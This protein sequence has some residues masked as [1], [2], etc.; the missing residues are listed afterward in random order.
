[1]LPPE[2]QGLDRDKMLKAFYKDMFVITADGKVISGRII[3]QEMKPRVYRASLYTGVVDTSS[4]ISPYVLF[5]EI[6]YPIN[7]RPKTITITPPIEEGYQSTLA[8]I[9]FIAYHKN[10]PVNDLRYLGSTEMLRL[11]W[12]DPWYSKFDNRNL[13]RHHSSSLL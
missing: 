10:I 5:T 6:E 13:K 2:L 4:T 11:D 3:N 9:G 8:N 12:Y 7:K 1:M